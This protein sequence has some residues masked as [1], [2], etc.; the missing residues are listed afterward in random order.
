[1]YFNWDIIFEFTMGNDV[2]TC[3]TLFSKSL[4]GIK[5]KVIR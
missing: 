4:Y 5:V 1:M 3:G 2:G